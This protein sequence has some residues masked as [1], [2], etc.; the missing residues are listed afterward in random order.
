M[1]NLV[2]A[3]LLVALAGACKTGKNEQAS[4]ENPPKR[5]VTATTLPGPDERPSSR[6][7]PA[8]SGRIIAVREALRFVVGD[9]AT[10][11]MPNLERRF[12]KEWPSSFKPP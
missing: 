5:T 2:L 11:N 6:P 7:V 9:C 1:R 3:F 12:W 10:G 8:V 4:T